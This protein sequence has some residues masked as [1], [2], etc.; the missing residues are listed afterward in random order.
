MRRLTNRYFATSLLPLRQTNVGRTFRDSV[1]SVRNG[2]LVWKSPIISNLHF[3][4]KRL[5]LNNITN[6]LRWNY[7]LRTSRIF[8]PKLQYFLS[9]KYI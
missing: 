6:L 7:V 3:H 2:S 5:T 4:S 8:G 9:F 1:R